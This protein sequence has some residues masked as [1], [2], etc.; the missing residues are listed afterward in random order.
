MF[1]PL[2]I[3]FIVLAFCAL[4]LT[5]ALFWLL[6]QAASTIKRVNDTMR[7]AQDTFCKVQETLEGIR[8]KFDNTSTAL[9]AIV[10]TATKAVEYLIEKRMDVSA[11]KKKKKKEQE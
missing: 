11:Q 4:W 3:L 1:S 9:G 7:A 6:W 10:H 5:A 8:Q 2:D